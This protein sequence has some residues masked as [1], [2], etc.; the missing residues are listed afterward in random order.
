MFWLKILG[1]K[2]GLFEKDGKQID[3]RKLYL[4]DDSDQEGLIGGVPFNVSI[5][6]NVMEDLESNY[7]LEA[8]LNREVYLSYNRWGKVESVKIL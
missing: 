3:Y 7:S 4:L 8:L 6:K 2:K 5:P 1:F